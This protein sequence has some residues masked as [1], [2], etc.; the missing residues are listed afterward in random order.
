VPIDLT[1]FF[2]IPI[3]GP[4]IQ[5]F[6]GGGAGA[7]V[8]ERIYSLAGV[9]AAPVDARTG[10]GI[11]VLGGASYRLS[12]LLA[13]TGEMKFRDLQFDATNAF[14]TPRIVHEGRVIEVST[15][16]FH[17]TIQTD[18]IVLHLGVSFSF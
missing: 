11:H 8:G 9:E 1:A 12:E 3:S 6:M 16:P 10:F 15:E 17:S 13:I 4:S 18:G 2:I 7:Y 14:T 5:V